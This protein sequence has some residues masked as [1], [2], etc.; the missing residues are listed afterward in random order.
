M[1]E[2]GGTTHS[3][4][5]TLRTNFIGKSVRAACRGHLSPSG[6]GADILAPHES[7]D[8]TTEDQDSRAMNLVISRC[9]DSLPTDCYVKSSPC[10]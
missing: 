2:A 6:A 10:S 4:S 5:D 7:R 3:P 8:D 9:Y 1:G